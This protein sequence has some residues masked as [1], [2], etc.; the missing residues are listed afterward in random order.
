MSMERIKDQPLNVTIQE[1]ATILGEMEPGSQ[2]SILLDTGFPTNWMDL[3]RGAGFA[4]F[5]KDGIIYHIVK[6]NTAQISQK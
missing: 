5:N 3:I 4:V 2:I 1:L 6:Q